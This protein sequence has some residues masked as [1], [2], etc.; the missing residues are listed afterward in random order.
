MALGETSPR[1]R[2]VLATGFEGRHG[3]STALFQDQA[4]PGKPEPAPQRRKPGVKEFTD[5]KNPFKRV[6]SKHMSRLEEPRKEKDRAGVPTRNPGIIPVEQSLGQERMR[7]E[8]GRYR[9]VPHRFGNQEWRQGKKPAADA[10]SP[11]TERAGP[12]WTRPG[13]GVLE[14]YLNDMK[15]VK[16]SLGATASS[17]PSD[18]LQRMNE[19]RV[20]LPTDRPTPRARARSHSCE[21]ATREERGVAAGA[22]ARARSLSQSPFAAVDAGD[23]EHGERYDFTRK[24]SVNGPWTCGRSDLLH[25]QGSLSALEVSSPRTPC[26]TR[27]NQANDRFDEMMNHMKANNPELRRDFQ[28]VKAKDKCTAGLLANEQVVLYPASERRPKLGVATPRSWREWGAS[29]AASPRSPASG[30]LEL[31]LPAPAAA[32]P[33][34]R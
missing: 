30:R 12:S 3:H 25:H 7:G 5:A 23:L 19:A 34:S 29:A 24:R 2:K 6:T 8:D 33:L 9:L 17:K 15:R 26:G 21:P 16:T 22:G 11:A 31:P 4:N 1:L 28:L 20:Y 32:S 14:N 10:A 18:V 13:N 27:V